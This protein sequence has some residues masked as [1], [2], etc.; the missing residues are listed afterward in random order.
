[1]EMSPKDHQGVVLKKADGKLVR[2]Y[3][4]ACGENEQQWH[5]PRDLGTGM[6]KTEHLDSGISVTLSRCRINRGLYARVADLPGV[7]TLVFSL[8]GRS[9][10]KNR[11][12]KQGFEL[13]KGM[14]CLYRFPA[15]NMI[16]EASGNQTLSAV[17][18]TIPE[19]RF[20]ALAGDYPDL[21]ETGI[22][23]PGEFTFQTHIS[24]PPM[25]QILHQIVQCRFHG[26]TRRLYLE[27]KALELLALKLETIWAPPAPPKKMSDAQVAAVLKV[28]NLLLADVCHPPSTHDLARA[29]GMSHP[30]LNRLF[31]TVFGCSPFELLRQKRLEWARD[32]VGAT[33]MS[34]TEIAYAT[35]YANSSHFSRAFFHRYGIQPSQYRK[36]TTRHPFYSLP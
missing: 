25:Q 18:I 4:Q 21:E 19:D 24:T 7:F 11:Q 28:R 34:M 8:E 15:R 35:G 16:R 9:L 20:M 30:R 10:N 3:A 36:K 33:E 22:G 27:A 23:M 14:N 32:L 29:A 2:V 6:F 31:K 17:V 13:T 1:M 26:L 12:L 5:F